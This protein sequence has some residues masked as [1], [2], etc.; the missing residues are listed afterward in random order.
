MADEIRLVTGAPGWLGT[1][2]VRS[3]SRGVAGRDDLGPSPGCSIRCLVLPEADVSGLAGTPGIEL[4]R[5]DLTDPAYLPA[6]LAGARGATLFHAAGLIHPP[7]RVKR[8]YEVNVRGTADLLRA[9]MEAGVR[10]FIHVSSNS[11]FGFNP[12]PARPFDESSPYHPYM[13]YGRSKKLAEDEVNRAGATGRIE[14]VIVRPAWFH[15]P[16]H[17]PRQG[18]FI[19]MVRQGRAPVV[20]DGQN[21][22][23]MSHV[24]NICQALVLCDRTAAAAG[25]TYWITDREAYSMNRIIETIATVLRRDF[26]LSV[27]DRRPRL[28]RLAGTMA[29]AADALIQ[30]AGFYQMDLHVL[31]EMPRTIWAVSDR[32]GRELGYDPKFGVEDGMRQS[33]QEMLDHHLPI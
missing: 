5:G 27:S 1:R 26:G 17:P 18:R 30:A 33:I 3:L 20:G 4:V 10:R 28:P 16:G 15:G 12:D 13:N 14:T 2:L 19:S 9:A 11:P 6:F 31:S 24:D 21:L 32:A 22:R 23:S 8:L 7:G 29:Q 25:R